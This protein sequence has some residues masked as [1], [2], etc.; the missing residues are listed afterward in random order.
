MIETAKQGSFTTY[1][2]SR[3]QVDILLL[4]RFMWV[5]SIALAINTTPQLPIPNMNKQVSEMAYQASTDKI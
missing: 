5:S 2:L 3:Q 4:M 1:L